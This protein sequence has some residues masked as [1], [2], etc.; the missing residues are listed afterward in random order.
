MKF[1]FYLGDG[2]WTT[3]DPSLLWIDSQSKF[4]LPL[5]AGLV[6]LQFT[7]NTKS[8]V[9]TSL[10][11]K[12][13]LKSVCSQ[14]TLNAKPRSAASFI[15]P[16]GVEPTLEVPVHVVLAPTNFSTNR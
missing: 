12:L 1:I 16:I 5:R 2:V 10:L 9:Q 3:S 13:T 15:M 8:E 4:M 7:P 6:H 11:G 14:S